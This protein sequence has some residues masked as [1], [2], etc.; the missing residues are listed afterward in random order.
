VLAT[1]EEASISA[2]EQGIFQNVTAKYFAFAYKKA[3]I[4][5]YIGRLYTDFIEKAPSTPRE[6]SVVTGIHADR[7]S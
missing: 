7:L 4:W 6:I 1:D 2:P 5:R 3:M